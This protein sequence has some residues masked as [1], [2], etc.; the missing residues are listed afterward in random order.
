MHVWGL[1]I[2]RLLKSRDCG[3]RLHHPAGHCVGPKSG[4]ISHATWGMETGVMTTW[5]YCRGPWIVP[6]R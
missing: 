3:L 2:V 6:E 5:S 1:R 4:V